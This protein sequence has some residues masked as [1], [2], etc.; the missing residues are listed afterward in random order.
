MT[1]FTTGG[2]GGAVNT[3]YI[4]D[5]TGLVS[6][7]DNTLAFDYAISNPD[8]IPLL[9]Q[10]TIDGSP[11]PLSDPSGSV[12]SI[13]NVPPTPTTPKVLVFVSEQM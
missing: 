5:V 8:A 1:G 7:T 12:I 3:D 11:F 6:A 13:L 9:T 10:Y 2:T 4:F